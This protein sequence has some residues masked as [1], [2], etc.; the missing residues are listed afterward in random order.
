MS[1]V[2][3]VISNTGP[4]G[5][6]V[7]A[8]GTTGQSLV[9]SSSADYATQWSDAGSGTVTS[10]GLSLPG[11]FTVTGSPVTTAGTLTAALATQQAARLFAGPA[12]GGDAAPTFRALVATDLPN[13]AV[14]PGAYTYASITV[15]AQGRLTSAA[16]GTIPPTDLSYDAATRLLSSSTGTDATLPLAT[17][18]LDGLMSAAHRAL[19]AA[20][21]AAGVSVTGSTVAIPHIHGDLAGSI[22]IHVKNTSGVELTK[23]TPVRVV[24]AVGDT[25]TLEVAAADAASTGTMPAIGILADTLAPN[26]TGHAVVAGELL[27]LATGS[28]SIGQALY[29]AAGGGLTGTK[30]TSGTVQQVAIVGRV[31]A[32]T[33]SVTVTIGA[34]RPPDHDAVTLATSVA[35]VLSVSGQELQADDPGGD[36]I[37]FWDDSESK[38]RHLSLAGGMF[39][40]GTTL[41]VPVEIGIACSDET[42]ALTTGTAKATFRMPFP[43]NLT[44]VRASS[45]VA[46]AGS[47]LIVDINEAGVS[48]L[49]TKLSIDANEKT[50]TTA[51][52]A[53]V[54]SDSALA[55]DAEIT[56]DIDQIGATTAGAGLKVWLIGVRV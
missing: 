12:T 9:K 41:S 36:R 15:D 10:V 54:I 7:P 29:V 28:Y 1:D 35:D 18:S 46:P 6:G 8:G 14:T 42:T 16:N 32:A 37:L 19:S 30:P 33:G 31:N 4:Q 13:T 44:E 17:D 40:S 2:T 3:V 39:I 22:Y 34:Q 43:M 52:T 55:D 23:G 24:G 50:S 27:G 56:I 48:V 51:A 45:T 11:L 5:A 53:A 20:L 47:N 26:G 49:S 25:S 21:I 38:L